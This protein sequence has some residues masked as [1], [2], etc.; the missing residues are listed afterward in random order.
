MRPF[1]APLTPLV[2][3]LV[4]SLLAAP[5]PSHPTAEGFQEGRTAGVR[6]MHS[7][8][9]LSGN[10]L[11]GK[12]AK[13][14]GYR[15]PRPCWY[16]PYKS[17]EE[18]LREEDS[19]LQHAFRADPDLSS[20]S[21]NSR[22]YT[23]D[24]LQQYRDKLGQQGRWWRAAYNAG[25][26]NGA[27]CSAALATAVWVPTGTTPP[28]GITAEELRA[29]ARAALTVPEPQ[30]KLSPDAK[31]YVNLP[32]WVWLE[33]GAQVPRSVTATLPG[34][35]SVTV[36]ATPK[37]VEIDPGTTS[38]RAEV[39]EN[40]GAGGRPYTKGGD[41]TCGVRYLRASIDQSRDVYTLTVTSVWQV[42][43]TDDQGGQP[44]PFEPIR[45][46][47]TRDVPV[48]EVQSVVTG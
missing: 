31:S 11:G 4:A 23:N 16:E 18:M 27:A 22:Q 17:A 48:G 45:A 47:A 37:N 30:V 38:D 5:D 15:I 33:G 3:S 43:S 8:I 34:F 39:R 12:G 9:V 2:A 41:F 46:A 21:S 20:S 44:F 6:L 25:D 32:T 26:Q 36:T 10:G 35:M 13:G 1:A 19:T 28:G 42:V 24:F 14:D 40:C 29:I 7:A